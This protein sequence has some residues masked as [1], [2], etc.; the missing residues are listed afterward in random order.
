VLPASD[1][2]GPLPALRPGDVHVWLYE[3]DGPYPESSDAGECLDAAERA[4]SERLVRER[5]RLRYRASHCAVR[6][7]AASYLDCAPADVRITRDCAHCGHPS[8][9]KPAWAA[10]DGRRIEANASHSDALGALAVTPYD[11]LRLGL[12]V[13]FRRPNVNWKGILHAAEPPEDGFAEWTK[14]EAVAKAAGT[15]IVKMPK[16]AAPAADGWAVGTLDTDWFVRNLWAPAG[17]AA[18]LAVSSLPVEIQLRW[19]R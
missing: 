12:D 11:G 8:H 3:L 9:G 10:P 7:L 6:H 4:K 5:D 19:R 17:F 18:A 15:G 2:A 14:L 1:S 13:E 16:L